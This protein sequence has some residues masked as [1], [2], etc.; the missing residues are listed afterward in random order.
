MVG[1]SWGCF[2]NG[3]A[4]N[5]GFYDDQWAPVV[6]DGSHSQLIEVNTKGIIE[7]DADRYAGIYQTVKVKNWAHYTLNLRG[8]IRTTVLDGDPW[9]Y[10]VEVGWSH[11]PH[12][13]WGSVTNWTDVGWN[14]YYERTSPGAMQEFSTNLT[15]EADQLT[16]YVRVWK[17]WG[18]SGEEID[19]NL[20]AISL[21]GP[22]HQGDGYWHKGPGK[23]EP[24]AKHPK[25]EEPK[26][27]PTYEHKH[28]PEPVSPAPQPAPIYGGACTGQEHL[29]N[30]G[31]E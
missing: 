17:K 3:G 18:V 4:A 27:E 31:F 8:V 14:N 9:R 28:K 1:Y 12:A 20:D 15:A 21:T 13:S 6:A 24:E 22:A 10:R 7:G 25:Y 26:P 11:G 16:V 5:Y 19:I 2:T 29:Y 23:G 30:G